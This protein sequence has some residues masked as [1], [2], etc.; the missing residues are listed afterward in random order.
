VPS[1]PE[2][3]SSIPQQPSLTLES[4]SDILSLADM[5]NE[6]PE[7]KNRVK[8]LEDR[9]IPETTYFNYSNSTT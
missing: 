3:S 8:S 7:L 4:L 5:K 1:P 9:K 6:I 2:D